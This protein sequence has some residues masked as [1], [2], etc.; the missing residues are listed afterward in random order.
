M[1]TAADLSEI[2]TGATAAGTA[3]PKPVQQPATPT[4]A[5]KILMYLL[6]SRNRTGTPTRI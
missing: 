1:K 5:K 2:A 6:N 3:Q 4:G